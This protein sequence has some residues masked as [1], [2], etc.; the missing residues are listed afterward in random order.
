[1]RLLR[2]LSWLLLVLHLAPATAQTT[3][4]VSGFLR[5]AATG[6]ALSYGTVG[7]AGSARGVNTN[8]YGFYSLQVPAGASVTL[9]FSFLGYATATRTVPAT[10]NL[11]LD[12]KLRATDNK[13]SEVVVTAGRSST[14]L[15]DIRSTQTS[16][17][18]IPIDE[19]R[20]IPS[21]GGEVDIIKVIQLMPGITRGGEGSTGMFVRGGDAD[22]NLV[23]LDEAVVYNIGHLFGFFSVFNPDALRDVTVT[24]GGFPAHYGGRLSSVLDVR[25]KEGNNQH[26]RV[27]GGIGLL[28]SRLT[29]EAP[30]VKNKASFLISGRRT[31]ID[32]AF[33]LIGSDVP[34]YFYDLNAKL[35]YEISERDHL[36]FSSYFGNDV[37]SFKDNKL[38]DEVSEDEDGSIDLNLNFGFELGNFTQTVRWNR[39]YNPK[40][41]S[42]LSLIRTAFDYNIDGKVGE[43]AILIKS[44]IQDFGAKI[45]YTNFVD[46][47]TQLR[48][49]GALTV[50]RFR[51]NVLNAAGEIS[52][53]IENTEG[54]QL[55]TV[56]PA[57]YAG[58]ETRLGERWTVQ[59][60]LR[61][62]GAVVKDRNYFGF[63]PRLSTNYA[64][65]EQSSIKASYSRMKQYIHR[66]SSSSLALPTDLWY[67]VSAAVRPQA[68]HQ[69]AAGYHV[70]FPE[71]NLTFSGEAYYKTMRDVIEY[72][73]GS[74]LILNDN[75]EEQLLQGDGYSWGAEFLLR[76]RAGRVNGWLGYTLA[77]SRRQFDELNNGEGFWARYDRR[78]Y[79]TFVGNWEIS[80]RFTFSTVFEYASG[81]RFTPVVAQFLYP[82]PTLTTVELVPIY[83]KRNAL[84]L[85][86]S[87]RLDV[88]FVWRNKPGKR[89]RSEWH[90]GAYNLTNRATPYT[91]RVNVDENT[92]ALRYEQP[93][94]FGFVPSVAYNF[95]F[96][97]GPVVGR[98]TLD[99]DKR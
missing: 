64:L 68:S 96:G 40:L 80:P 44:A 3:F 56:E 92:G 55:I 81:A 2:A 66:V 20:T 99:L 86:D 48:W 83:T 5:D 41:F 78:H 18:T 36:Y 43:N 60:G 57:L 74:D 82:D 23:L 19:I 88:N 95:R 58:G 45:D 29:I 16:T 25:M 72:R 13:I 46:D 76:R 38:S 94:L 12:V 7:V 70:L 67:P 93:G 91:V 69:V 77:W 22:Q 10:G 21:L 54:P 8:D 35:N 52:E 53:F 61:L 47:R 98:E 97:G 59:G 75:F 34:F 9:Q 4:S 63:E 6:E 32:Q 11:A 87:Y 62:S 28:S 1:M 31:Y 89:F 39:I 27:E 26:Y 90:V 79:L 42:N 71:K 15:E 73:E 65:G 84:S 50:H 85:S 17:V 33:G 30:I 49:G 14:E 37:L 24:K 51:P